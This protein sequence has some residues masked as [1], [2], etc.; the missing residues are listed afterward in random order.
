MARLHGGQPHHMRCIRDDE[1]VEAQLATQQILQQFRRDGR[2]HDVFVSYARPQS[3]GV[4]RHGDMPNHE[5]VDTGVDQPSVHPA[6]GLVPLR[7]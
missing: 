2:R 6:V 3:A 5:T 4:G 7:D 1:P